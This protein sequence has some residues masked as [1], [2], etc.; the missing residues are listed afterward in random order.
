M[1]GLLSV[2][3]RRRITGQPVGDLPA[4]TDAPI[5]Y[6]M[7]TAAPWNAPTPAIIPTYDGS[8]QPTH[9]SVVDMLA[10]RGSAWLGYRYW[11]CQTPYP[12]SDSS[13]ENPSIVVSNNGYDWHDTEVGITNPIVPQ[14]G[15]SYNSDGDILWNPDAGRL[16]M[17]YRPMDAGERIK[18][19]HS[20]DGRTWS[21]P[22]TLLTRNGTVDN[23]ISP[24][25]VRES[26]S[27]WRIYVR[28]AAVSNVPG[29]TYYTAPSPEGPWGNP[30]V[31]TIAGQMPN[32]DTTSE[33]LW[34]LKVLREGAIYYAFAA[35]YT[36]T[37]LYPGVSRDGVNFTFGPA[38]I[39]R[40]AGQWDSGWLY[41]PTMVPHENGTGMRVWYA[42][43]SS[44]KVGYTILPRSLWDSLA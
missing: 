17:I 33:Q 19:L 20:Y 44:G 42:A 22:V 21:T 26:S 12:A 24:S 4:V 40:R 13:K 8:N 7:P 43:H 31:C 28:S 34:H 5:P 36:S 25:L 9:P 2:A 38:A 39:Q 37:N 10:A 41:R 11:M 3:R 15:T 1:S 23:L 14:P 18:G 32:N 6:A 27:E 16:E 29:I 30:V 35:T